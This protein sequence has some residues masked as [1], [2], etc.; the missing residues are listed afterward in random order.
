MAG[1]WRDP[2]AFRA[3]PT[4]AAAPR[5]TRRQTVAVLLALALV[6]G[7]VTAASYLIKPN[8]ARTFDLF[9]GSIFLGDN[10][11]P[12]AVDLASGKPTIRLADA[13]TQ[14][15]AVHTEDV[16]V[17]PMSEGTL[18]LNRVTGEFNMVDS[19]G[20]VLKTNGGVPVERRAGATDTTG[21]AAK[22]FAYIEQTGPTGTSVFLVGP[23]TVQSASGAR[24]TAQPRA[25]ASMNEPGRT[26]PGAAAS[27]GNDL[28]LLVGRGTTHTVRHLSLPPNS[29]PGVLLDADDTGAVTGPA[30]IASSGADTDD[31]SV[32]V[33]SGTRLAVHRSD[34]ESTTLR[35]SAPA[36]LDTVLPVSNNGDRLSFL[37]HGDAGWS[38]LSAKADGTGLRGPTPIDGIAADAQL[39][40]PAASNGRLYTVD[41]DGGRLIR[42]DA[43]ARAEGV[44]G[45]PT[46]PLA[47]QKGRT[48][49]VGDFTDAY[50]VA[51][52]SRV[53]INSPNRLQAVALFTDGSHGP[54]VIDKGDAVTV[55]AAGGAEALT[56]SRND[57]PGKTKQPDDGKP[58][59][60]PTTPVNNNIDCEA[61]SQKPHIPELGQPVPGSRSVLL[62]W[63]YP[64]TGQADCIPSTYEIA[65]KLLTNSAPSPRSQVTVQGQ[66]S[67]NLTGLFPSTRYE[68]SVTAYINGK[69]TASAPIQVTTGPEGPAEPRS[70]TVSADS[71]GNWRIGW[72]S[73]GSE[74]NG[75][76][77]SESWRVI[78]Q[79][80]DDR[81]LS[82][83][84]APIEVAA[85]PTA[86]AQPGA[87]LRGGTAL[88]GRGLRFQVEGIGEQGAIGTPSA[89]TACTY[90]WSPP[91]TSAMTLTASHPRDAA[92]GTSSTT[93]VS[94]DLGSDPVLTAGGVGATL[95]FQL[96]GPNGTSTRTIT[97]DGRSSTPSVTFDGVRAGSTYHAS[98]VVTPPGH[99]SA[100]ASVGPV[101]VVS[102]YNWP[103][104]GVSASCPSSGLFTCTLNVKVLG[105]SSAQ[106]GDE[107]F[108]LT[109]DSQ[110]RCGEVSQ[111]I[112]KNNFDPANTAITVPN[113]SQLK[114][115]FGDCK[116]TVGLV[117]SPV[118]GAPDHP[119]FG[120]APSPRPTAPV[121]LGAPTHADL[122]AADFKAEWSATQ[123]S[124]AK[125]TY[126]GDKNLTSLTRDWTETVLAPDGSDTVCGTDQDEFGTV[127]SVPV[128]KDCIDQFGNGPKTWKVE[129]SYRNR[130]DGTAG[131]TVT[132]DLPGSPPSYQPCD[133]DL[134]SFRA[135]WGATR[136]DGVTVTAEGQLAG[137]SDWKYVLR[138][139]ASPND[140][141]NTVEDSHAPTIIIPAS[142]AAPPTRNW[143]V[144]ITWT[145]PD[146]TTDQVNPPT[147]VFGNPPSS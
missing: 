98:A 76:V 75:C 63:N 23:T 117:E 71:A 5:P 39:I 131:D 91:V 49:E 44:T 69:G 101:D 46:Y 45:M 110:L 9:H 18:L 78:A 146:G 120:A 33:A 130:S 26:E 113:V 4:A 35:Y 47:E 51:R 143:T 11:A 65:V 8:T 12:V 50:A 97:Y 38:L 112:Q 135:S 14:V 25:S 62:A 136:A 96:A 142:C 28:W 56:R 72:A 37:L 73:C 81:G 15:G 116:V 93:T 80:C 145:R 41:K 137:C 100:S 108:D 79:F 6:A 82:G 88:L 2:A 115:F 13:N 59:R 123:G 94:L 118:P 140:E 52:G 17:V 124:S 87:V 95:A 111:T 54:L 57:E 30:A 121:Q 60:T 89:A 128:T 83:A 84:P 61:T 36:G 109:E 85:D 141:C 20:F 129:L 3:D 40:A 67:V 21:I 34:G 68:I 7:A 107:R 125:I 43:D 104:L 70:V 31:W 1:R 114:N 105:I 10:V 106:V 122:S 32:G 99:P 74:R 144:A 16:A 133:P 77:P 29:D 58:G 103:T 132:I 55:S 134:S 64:I 119:Y 102:R 92:V 27:A 139:S 48:I 147:P 22:D 66:R 126:T 86:V 24:S 19:T 138:S 90:S 127:A 53:I 42:I